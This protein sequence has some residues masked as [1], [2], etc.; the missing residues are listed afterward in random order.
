MVSIY[1]FRKALRIHDNEGLL[2]A[3]KNGS[4]VLPLFILDPY[5]VKHALV[6]R[7][8]WIFLQESLLDLDRQLRAL[9]SRLYVIRG[10]PHDTFTRLFESEQFHSLYFEVDTE[11]YAVERDA[12]IEKLAQQNNVS[13]HRNV[14]H[15]LFDT[16]QV[17]E[18]NKGKAPLTYKLFTD[19]VS[20][21]EV[22]KC[23][24][25]IQ[26]LTNLSDEVASKA[27]SQISDIDRQNDFMPPSLSELIGGELSD[28]EK[29]RRHKGG[30]Q[31][32]L[33]RLQQFLAQVDKVASF[34]KP[35]TSPAA[36]QPA[37][38]T[39]LSPYLKF[40][41][42]SSRKFY[43]DLMAVCKQH[44][45]YTKPPVSLLGQLFWRE[46]FYTASSVTPSFHKMMGNPVCLQIPWKYRP[47]QPVDMNEKQL[48]EAWRDAETGYPWI[49]AIMTQLRDEGWIHHLARHSVAC[50]LTRGDLYVSWERG[51]E[52]FEEL[53]LD[54]DYAL[55]AGNWMWLSAS[56]FFYQYFRIYNPITFGQQYDKEGAY[57]KRYLPVLKNVPQNYIYQPWKMPKETQKKAG[58]IIGVDYPRPIVD[59]D[60]VRKENI[61][62]MKQAYALHIMGDQKDV[63]L[64]G[65]S[66]DE[67]SNDF[68]TTTDQIA[69]SSV[70]G[71]KRSNQSQ[72]STSGSKGKKQKKLTDMISK[73]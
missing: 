37:S 70:S 16:K 6:G 1:W 62:K 15:T 32:A 73:K 47:D 54:A 67:H 61:D 29:V 72:S 69:S 21:I 25:A 17:V 55:N 34:E 53:L 46:F 8:R 13:V 48:F 22:G 20:R 14:G 24:D 58:C 5:F 52:V 64:L 44:K 12:D 28:E 56:T 2:K 65:G 33:Y 71:Q 50:F 3:A 41:C 59:H 43:H 63:T 31:E 49:D 42:L 30:E 18:M 10:N 39:V 57:I 7:N 4:A 36:F 40:G 19:I 9:G 27:L 26:S 35:K 51:V 38:T 66:K 68:E 45:N 23:A 11:P 60:I